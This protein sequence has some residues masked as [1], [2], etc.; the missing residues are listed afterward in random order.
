MQKNTTKKTDVKLRWWDIVQKEGKDM[1]PFPNVF[2]GISNKWFSMNIISEKNNNW[3]TSK[4]EYSE[5]F[6]LLLRSARHYDTLGLKVVA[7]NPFETPPSYF[8]KDSKKWA[9][10]PLQLYSWRQSDY[11]FVDL[12]KRLKNYYKQTRKIPNIGIRGYVVVDFDR[13]SFQDIT[14]KN[15][16]GLLKNTRAISTA[17]GGLHFYFNISERTAT[18]HFTSEEGGIDFIGQEQYVVAPPSRIAGTEYMIISDKEPLPISTEEYEQLRDSLVDSFNLKQVNDSGLSISEVQVKESY[19]TLASGLKVPRISYEDTV[20]IY[21]Y[22]FQQKATLRPSKVTIPC[23]LHPDNHTNHDINNSAEIFKATNTGHG[24]IHC[25]RCGYT[26]DIYYLLKQIL[27][28]DFLDSIA[29]TNNILGEEKYHTIDNK[30]YNKPPEPL[31]EA[32]VEAE[33]ETQ[34]ETRDKNADI[35]AI[36]KAFSRKNSKLSDVYYFLL[37][38]KDKNNHISIPQSTIAQKFS[39]T[40][41]Q[42]LK[43]IEKLQRLHLLKLLKSGKGNY[44]TPS[45]YYIENIEKYI[46]ISKRLHHNQKGYIL[47]QKVTSVSVNNSPVHQH[48]AEDKN[49]YTPNSK[50]ITSSITNTPKPLVLLDVDII[51]A[52][53]KAIQKVNTKPQTGNPET[54]TSNSGFKTGNSGIAIKTPLH[55]HQPEALEK[56]HKGRIVKLHGLKKQPHSLR[57]TESND[58]PH[59]YTN[60]LQPARKLSLNDSEPHRKDSVGVAIPIISSEDEIFRFYSGMEDK[61]IATRNCKDG[62]R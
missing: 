57:A 56:H 14:D 32:P 22:L 49:A 8:K 42:V 36:Q 19:I 47:N 43:Y 26:V 30:T 52:N 46:E 41:I 48:Q 62:V 50:P 4:T 27:T 5:N 11:S 25:Y 51:I 6:L 34:T 39:F 31:I 16:L 35:G 38:E 60:T 12:S 37:G 18:E 45:E 2:N 59:T 61:I 55:Q 21:N 23:P 17:S 28:L 58:K 13:L 54:Q 7:L 40:R 9:K 1:N 15:V 53:S 29:L 33:I 44:H 24:F 10:A 20:A 3:K